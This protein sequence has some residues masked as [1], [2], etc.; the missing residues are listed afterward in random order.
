VDQSKHLERA[1]YSK[2]KAGQVWQYQS[3]PGEE[4]SYATVV[5]VEESPKLGVI[6]HINLQGLRMKNPSVPEGIS[7]IVAHM[8]FLEEA[9]DRSVLRL[10]RDDASIPDFRDG[11]EQWREAFEEGKAGVFSISIAESIDVMEE[12]FNQ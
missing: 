3:R 12:A 8:P 4:A 6:V 11:Y 1:R 10:L 2:Y 7:S 5:K 9:I